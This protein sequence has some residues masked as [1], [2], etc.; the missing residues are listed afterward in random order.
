VIR[1]LRLPLACDLE[2]LRSDLAA[3][4]PAGWHPH[5]NQQYYSGDWSGIPLRGIPDSRVPL[6]ADPTRSDFAD[7]ELMSR[8]RYV[9]QFLAELRC[10]VESVRFLKLAPGSVIR[11]HRDFG[12]C[13]EEAAIRL[14]IPV[15]THADVEFVLDGEPL[16]LAAGECWYVNFDLKHRLA[17]RGQSDRVHLVVDARVNAWVESLFDRAVQPIQV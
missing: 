16:T 11:E 7:T 12:L 3:V 13:F 15:H 10:P 17:N 5:F 8:C 4:A 2:A 9:P 1:H 14:H 6:Y